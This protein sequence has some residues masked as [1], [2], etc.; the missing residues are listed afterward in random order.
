MLHA[1]VSLRNSSVKPSLFLR[2]LSYQ[3]H[4]DRT[5]SKLA[6][7]T[8]YAMHC[9]DAMLCICM[10]SS[11]MV[12]LIILDSCTTYL[13]RTNI[14]VAETRPIKL[15][16]IRYGAQ[17]STRANQWAV[18]KPSAKAYRWLDCTKQ[19]QYNIVASSNGWIK[20]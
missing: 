12:F 19:S 18:T 5:C 20:K 6:W 2:V 11:L 17:F 14:D 15:I 8:L 10:L 4:Q 3:F 9:I 7:S 13:A 16:T 1:T